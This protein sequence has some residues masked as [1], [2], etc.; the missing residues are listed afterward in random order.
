MSKNFVKGLRKCFPKQ[1]SPSKAVHLASL[2]I[3][4][5]EILQ[6]VN[7]S[8]HLKEEEY[9]DMEILSFLAHSMN[10]LN[11]AGSD[12][13]YIYISNSNNQLHE[14]METSSH[15]HVSSQK[16]FKPEQCSKCI[17]NA[18]FNSKQYLEPERKSPSGHNNNAAFLNKHSPIKDASRRLKSYS[19][20]LTADFTHQEKEEVLS[21]NRLAP[22]NEKRKLIRRKTWDAES[23]ENT[24]R[25]CHRTRTYSEWNH[26]RRR[27]QSFANPFENVIS[28]PNLYRKDDR[29]TSM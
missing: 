7:K 2:C 9:I 22:N 11:T 18:F 10:S 12:D 3:E 24:N 16:Y 5:Q 28:S 15:K 13:V 29:T 1:K 27:W 4:H 21:L 6:K 25:P 23:L 14:D 8:K 19:R 20:S 26:D 17:E